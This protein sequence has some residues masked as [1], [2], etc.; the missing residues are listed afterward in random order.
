MDDNPVV[1]AEWD[2]VSLGVAD[3]AFLMLL[4]L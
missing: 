1:I 4:A 2:A 3:T